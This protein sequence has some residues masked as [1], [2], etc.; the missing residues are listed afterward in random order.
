MEDRLFMRC[1]AAFAN[2]WIFFF[3]FFLR[4]F[5]KVYS[6]HAF[7]G[8]FFIFSELLAVSK[9]LVSLVLL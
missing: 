6:I 7:L 5:S 9:L 8:Q 3:F 2:F 4:A 1:V